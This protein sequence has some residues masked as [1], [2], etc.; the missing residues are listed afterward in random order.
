MMDRSGAESAIQAVCEAALRPELWPDTLKSIALACQSTAA[1]AQ[2]MGDDG[3]VAVASRGAEG[4]IQDYVEGDWQALNTRNKRGLDMTRGG[5]RGFITEYHMFEAEELAQDAFQQEFAPRHGIEAEAGIVAASHA[6][7][8]FILTI[9]RSSRAGPYSASELEAMNRLA[10]HISGICS[11]AL[12]LKLEA[13]SDVLAAMGARGEAL[14]LVTKTG[15]VVQTTASFEQLLAGELTLRSGR[16]RAKDAAD[17]RRLQALIQMAAS[18]PVFY[19][20]LSPAVIRRANAAP[21]LVRCLPVAGAARDLLGLARVVVTI[22]D[23]GAKRATPVPQQLRAAFGLSPAE[24]R[25]AA[26]LG[27]GETLRMAA[28]AEGVTFETSRSRLKAIFAKTGCS[29][30]TELVLLLARMGA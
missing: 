20:R 1:V 11:F 22:D 12:R 19:E 3:L 27:N 13:A 7:S 2:M 6:G 28:D 14:A 5:V 4:L 23:L 8:S 17:D 24:A 25:L 26:R 16:L 30:Q 21:L 10:D 15:R 29:R 9:P 18:W